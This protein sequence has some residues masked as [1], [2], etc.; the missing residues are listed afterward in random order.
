MDRSQGSTPWP[1][2]GPSGFGLRLN[3]SVGDQ[4]YVFATKLLLKFPYQSLLYSMVVFLQSVRH[5]DDD[6]LPVSICNVNFPGTSDKEVPQVGFQFIICSFQVE[7]CLGNLFFKLIR[8][9]TSLFMNFF[10]SS[11]H[12]HL[13]HLAIF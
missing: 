2:L 9:Y 7:E 13:K 3:S 12:Y 1:Q 5:V 8:L 11:K 4:H 10:A 6:R